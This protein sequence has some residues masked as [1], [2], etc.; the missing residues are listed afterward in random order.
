LLRAREPGLVNDMKRL[1]KTQRRLART[2]MFPIV[3]LVMMTTT[4]LLVGVN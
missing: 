2:M 3:A 1:S 4:M